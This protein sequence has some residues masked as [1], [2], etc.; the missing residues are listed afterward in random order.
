MGCNAKPAPR[1]IVMNGQISLMKCRKIDVVWREFRPIWIWPSK[2]LVDWPLRYRCRR[3][4]RR[5][6]IFDREP[7]PLVVGVTGLRA[8]GS[9]LKAQGSRLKAQ[10]SRLKA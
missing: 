6:L 2:S 4:Q 9:R 5:E 3:V 10:G 7:K 1:L 8:H